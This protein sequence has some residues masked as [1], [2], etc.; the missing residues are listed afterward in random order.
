MI[1]LAFFDMDGTLSAPRFYV[2]GR[3]VAGMT[4]AAWTEFCKKNGEKT[5]DYCKKVPLVAEYAEKLKSGVTRLYVLSTSQTEEEAAAKRRFTAQ[6]LPGIFDEVINVPHDRDKIP[7][8]RRIAEE[9]GV[10]PEECELVE[11]TYAL[12]L[13]AITA[14]MK[15]THVSHLYSGLGGDLS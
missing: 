9:R 14:G 1:K 3:M 15:G 11:D 12:V 5:Y 4:D 8:I 2:A 13:E 6:K 7:T 10:K